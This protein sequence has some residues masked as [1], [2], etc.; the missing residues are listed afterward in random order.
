MKIYL[1]AMVGLLL[2]GFVQA[3]AVEPEENTTVYPADWESL[4]KRPVPQWW[5]DAKF[6]IFIHWGVYAVPAYAPPIGKG[7]A[8]FSEWYW[9]NLE[10]NTPGF[11]EHHE[12]FY[13][14]LKYP[15]FAT[16]F[17]AEHYEPAQ[18]A[19]L[20]K[21]SGAK[22]IVLTSKHHDGYAL[23]PSEYSP[24]WNSMVVGSHRDLAGE[25]SEAVQAAGLHMGFY[26]S[27]LEWHNPLYVP[28]TADRWGTEMNLPQM[29]ELVTRYQPE[30]LW[31]DG[32][33]DFTDKQLHSEDFL[34]WLYNESPVK[35]TIV[36]NDRWGKGVR[37][38]HGGHRTSE[39][40]GT[41]SRVDP[42]FMHPW[43]ECRGIGYSFGYN[44]FETMDDYMTS[45]QCI[46]LLVDVV[47]RGGNLLLNIGPKANGL[48]PV[49]MQERLLD[50]GK[51]LDVNGEAIYGTKAWKYRPENMKETHVHFTKKPDALYVICTSWPHG[52]LVIE[53]ISGA[54]SVVLLG[55]TVPVEFSCSDGKL[56]IQPPTLSPGNLPCNFA[57]TF[58]VGLPK[59]LIDQ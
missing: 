54:D 44:Q 18:W 26:Y 24:R 46:E 55:S 16:Q 12:Q 28:E 7:S 19:G 58:K 53:H 50:M 8:R 2:G 13:G 45:D 56:T 52:P 42:D 5:Q 6:G 35:D 11:R 29:K 9:K 25:L 14:N 34:A 33:W 59:Q 36:V 4:D 43:E 3:E 1:Y 40:G 17:R 15:D 22:Y 27:L 20:F 23:W 41:H 31:T 49:I 21:Q 47:S 32:E 10:R 51:W 39:Y 37:W 57:W 48:I 30:V 38:Q